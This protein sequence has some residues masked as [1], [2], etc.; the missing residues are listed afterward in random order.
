VCVRV[1]G[2]AK[3]K[4]AQPREE[5]AVL[6]LAVLHRTRSMVRV[7]FCNKDT[8]YTTHES[9]PENKKCIQ[10]E[11]AVRVLSMTSA[12]SRMSSNRS[13]PTEVTTSFGGSNGCPCR[14]NAVRGVNLAS[15]LFKSLSE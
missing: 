13:C 15:R 7:L 2:E 1:K 3:E 14:R 12:D 5:S 6:G 9:A 10:L 8:V 4:L 11:G